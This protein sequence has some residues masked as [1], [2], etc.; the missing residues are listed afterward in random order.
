MFQLGR[1]ISIID[2]WCFVMCVE[3]ND[4]GWPSIPVHPFPRPF[5]IPDHHPINIAA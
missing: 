4:A 5:P 1:T 2:C 3:L